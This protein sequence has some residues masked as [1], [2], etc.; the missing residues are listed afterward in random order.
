MLIIS[1]Q[2]DKLNFF[3]LIIENK[4]SKH[5]YHNKSIIKSIKLIS[6]YININ[7][8]PIEI[9]IKYDPESPRYTDLI[10]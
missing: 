2:S 1:I 8:E 7:S 4:F 5:G 6:L 3:F 10:N 9:P